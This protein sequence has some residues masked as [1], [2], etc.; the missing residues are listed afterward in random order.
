MCSAALR[1]GVEPDLLDEIGYWNDDYWRYALY[2]AIALIRASAAK[3]SQ[4]VA[5]LARRL[6]ELHHLDLNP[7]PQAPTGN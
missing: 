7:P 3:T 4:P 1:G 5:E 2:A 6:A